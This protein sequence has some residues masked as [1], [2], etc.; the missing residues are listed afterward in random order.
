M[1]NYL[2]MMLIEDINIPQIGKIDE[3]FGTIREYHVSVKLS[4]GMKAK[5]FEKDKQL[6]IDPAKLLPLSRFLVT[7]YL[8]KKANSV[9]YND[10]ANKHV[11]QVPSTASWCQ[12]NWW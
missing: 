11:W 12:A 6:F 10:L 4:E 9:K 7:L 1:T 2:R 5:S 3:I 8:S